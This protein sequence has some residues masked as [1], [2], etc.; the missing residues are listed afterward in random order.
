MRSLLACVLIAV[1]P[2][3][4]A[5]QPAESKDVADIRA[6]LVAMWDTGVHTDMHQPVI[7]VRGDT[8]WIT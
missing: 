3:L 4:A 2:A 5:G 6:A 7:T 8:A 1:V